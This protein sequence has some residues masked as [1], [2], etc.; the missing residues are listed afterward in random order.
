MSPEP[1][2]DGDT[3]CPDTAL[4]PPRRA[5]HL[6]V[7]PLRFYRIWLLPPAAQR[8]SDVVLH[9]VVE[10]S[11]ERAAEV[12]RQGHPGYRVIGLRDVSDELTAA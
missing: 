2:R 10:E 5:D 3:G 8:E 7:N 6:A 11:D 4:T 9:C 1:P 12:A